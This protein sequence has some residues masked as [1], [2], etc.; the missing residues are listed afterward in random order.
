MLRHQETSSERQYFLELYDRLTGVECK[1]IFK[2]KN[3]QL[4]IP[5]QK[6]KAETQ[7]T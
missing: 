4:L 5:S 3:Q 7:E 2:E 6:C 1:L